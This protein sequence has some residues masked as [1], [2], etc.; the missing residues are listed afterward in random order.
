M[1]II[2]V[3]ASRP[4]PETLRPAAEVLRSGGLVAFPTETVYG[5]GALA[6]DE[7]AT[8]RVFAAKGRPASDPLI[9][10]VRPGWDLS[11][12]F[13]RVSPAM[14]LLMERHWPGPLTIVAE[15]HP[16]VVDLVTS[17]MPTV[18][19]R[20]PSHPVAALLLDLVGAPVVAPSANRF[21]YVSPT[22]AEHVARDLGDEIDMLVDAGRTPIG[23]ESTIVAVDGNTVTVLRRGSVV[24]DGAGDDIDAPP[25]ASPGR[26]VVHYAPRSRT[27]LIEAGASAGEPG[28]SGVVVGYADSAP[29]PDGWGMVSLGDR[30]DLEDVAR[31]LYR[32]LR[33][34]DAAE[35]P[36]IAIELTG[37]PG[38]G[39]A[40]D[41]RIRRAAG[42]RYLR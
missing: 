22:T 24:I 17:G 3:D 23:I 12:V 37:R 39:A 36:T 30:A 26:L 10:H 42:G 28:G 4:K 31:R 19:V 20:A 18:A 29:A 5:L 40:I 8:A 32:V 41:D 1:R 6:G 2:R 35:P 33:E 34:V 9:V 16:A 27:R 11:A 15:K 21:S 7:A 14:R 38:L 25:S 13:A